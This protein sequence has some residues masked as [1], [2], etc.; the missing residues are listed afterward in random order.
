MRDESVGVLDGKA[1]VVTG[2]GRGL[3]RAYALHA[4]G[5]GAWVV[6]NDVDGHEAES[7]AGEIRAA[8]EKAIA[9]AGSVA[10][11][12]FAGQ[13]V[14]ACVREFGAL[15]GFVNNAG[16]YYVTEPWDDDERRIRKV[17]EVNVLGTLFCGAHALG[18]MVRQGHG[19]LVNITSGAHAGL[20]AM[21]TYAASKGAAA[22]YTYAA[23][24]DAAPHGVRVNAVSPIAMTRM[25]RV[26]GGQLSDAV[27]LAGDETRRG[28][29]P[30]N[31]A[32]L[33]T[34]LLS[35][36]SAGITG[37]VVRLQGREL[38]LIEHPVVVQ[39]VAEAEGWS[40]GEIAAAFD[41][42]LR[43]QLR[44]YRHG[45]AAYRAPGAAT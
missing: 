25:G 10:D 43:K 38:S 28:P 16:L 3:G 23:A 14:A 17:V 30:E 41:G 45:A 18:Q 31:V 22:S 32:P 12:D 24:I 33:V 13:L 21:S 5:E 40:V 44:P 19:S 42:E 11:W 35:D 34:F 36:L 8:G 37:Q 15:D 39:P 2:A 26:Q 27:E 1:V 4:A 9:C 6:V 7:V 20:P 29:G